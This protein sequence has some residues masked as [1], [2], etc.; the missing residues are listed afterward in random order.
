MKPR[1]PTKPTI[2]IGSSSKSLGVAQ[3]LRDGLS[4]IGKVTVWNECTALDDP[5]SHL[6]Q[7]LLGISQVFDF[8]IM[9]FGPDDNLLTDKS[10]VLKVPR[11]NV[12]FEL[13][14]FMSQLGP[15]RAFVVVAKGNEPLEIMND[16]EGLLYVSYNPLDDG[17]SAIKRLAAKIEEQTI[18][19]TRRLVIG[20]EGPVGVPEFTTYLKKEAERRWSVGETVSV[21]NFA[22]DMEVTWGPLRAVMSDPRTPNL[23]WRAL[24]LDPEWDGFRSFASDSISIDQA[25]TNLVKVR[26]FMTPAQAQNL[27]DR[28]IDFRLR[29]YRNIPFVHGFMLNESYLLLTLL[30]RDQGHLISDHNSYF[31]F[32]ARNETNEHTFVA[33]STCFN[34]AW[35]QGEADPVWPP[36]PK[37]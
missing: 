7:N 15:G 26:Q 21:D 16:I 23:V 36:A 19:G 37:P 27:I 17:Q 10:Q 4:K 30:R 3:K 28:K 34:Y 22:L 25:R 29:L 32:A 11:D 1:E 8:A 6:L 9:V 18:R 13:G 20:H 12:I 24:M 2:F 35:E 33:Y 14:L 5:G 31:R